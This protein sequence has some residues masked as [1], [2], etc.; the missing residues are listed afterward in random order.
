MARNIEEAFKE[1]N[2]SISVSPAERSEALG[3]ADLIIEKIKKSS[4]VDDCFAS[5]SL[6]RTT[7][8]REFS[9]LDL[10]MVLKGDSNQES[11]RGAISRA[12][13]IIQKIYPEARRSSNTINLTLSEGLS[14]D[15]LPAFKYS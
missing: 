8:I 15:I 6:V 13:E 9:D 3:S 12:M 14:V 1:F 2:K 5:G 11:P 7:A 4:I 10:V